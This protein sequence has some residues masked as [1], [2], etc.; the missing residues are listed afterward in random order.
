[1]D[2]HV[3]ECEA[4]IADATQS[5]EAVERKLRETSEEAAELMLRLDF[6]RDRSSAAEQKLDEALQQEEPIRLMLREATKT[7]DRMRSEAEATLEEAR[8]AANR[9]ASQIVKQAMDKANRIVADAKVDRSQLLVSGRD[10]LAALER[11]ATQRIVDRE[12]DKAELTRRINEIGSV[13][14]EL[15]QT[16][17]SFLETSLKSVSKAQNCN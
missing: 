1:M 9:E 2:N 10:E 14:D 16:L 12:A 3:A 5:I 11:D 4:R 17:Q 6:E 15:A 8:L 13:Y 7:R